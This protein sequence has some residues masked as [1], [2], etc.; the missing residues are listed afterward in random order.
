MDT[1]FNLK[2]MTEKANSPELEF[3][4]VEEP[5]EEDLAAAQLTEK[6]WPENWRLR[7]LLDIMMMMVTDDN[8]FENMC[9]IIMMIIL[10]PP[11]TR[12]PHLLYCGV[13]HPC[14]SI[15]SRYFL[16]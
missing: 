11:G 6:F 5:S 3:V 2:L 7:V 16:T 12:V 8:L 1:N 14:K 9:N 15:K 13:T 4:M 10:A